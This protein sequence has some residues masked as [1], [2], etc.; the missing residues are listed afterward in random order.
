M[1]K[2]PRRNRKSASVR[3]LVEETIV[4][5]ADLVAPFFVLSGKK[6]R[7][8]LKT[9]PGV[10]SLSA[11]ELVKEAEKLHKGGIRGIALFPIVETEKKD[12]KGS[13][14]LDAKCALPN[15]IRLLKKEL[16]SLC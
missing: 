3:S 16:P 11:D 15:A 8:V 9:M 14:A 13:K 5:P 12:A 2:R 1:L 6:R 4:R 10:E 7:Q